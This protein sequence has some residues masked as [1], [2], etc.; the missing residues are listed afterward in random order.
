LR[1]WRRIL[2]TRRIHAPYDQKRDGQTQHRP[3]SKSH[4]GR[5]LRPAISRILLQ[6]CDNAAVMHNT[7]N[8]A[9]NHNPDSIP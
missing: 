9:E 2:G 3:Q 8:R 7:E 1:L 5:S 4:P 6:H